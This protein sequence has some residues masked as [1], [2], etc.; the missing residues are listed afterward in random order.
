VGVSDIIVNLSVRKKQMGKRYVPVVV[1]GSKHKIY[2][3][4]TLKVHRA[5]R[6]TKTPFPPFDSCPILR[7]PSSSTQEE[8][9]GADE[10]FGEDSFQI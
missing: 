2:L 10:T 7:K 5:V 1:R 6:R 8:I 4:D 9:G 3:D